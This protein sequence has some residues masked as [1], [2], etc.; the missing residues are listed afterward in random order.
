MDD[1][2]DLEPLFLTQTEWNALGDY[3]TSR[4]A[5]A[6]ALGIHPDPFIGEITEH[7][8]LNGFGNLGLFPEWALPVILADAMEQARRQPH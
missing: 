1:D 6:E 7:E 8:I 3:V 5:L 2:H 4:P